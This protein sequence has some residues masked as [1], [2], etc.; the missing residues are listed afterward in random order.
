MTTFAYPSLLEFITSPYNNI[1]WFLIPFLIGYC[2]TTAVPFS[3]ASQFQCTIWYNLIGSCICSVHHWLCTGDIAIAI[4]VHRLICV[5]HVTLFR[6]FRL[7]FAGVHMYNCFEVLAAHNMLKSDD[8]MPNYHLLKH[9]GK[10]VERQDLTNLFQSFSVVFTTFQMNKQYGKGRFFVCY[11]SFKI[12]NP[13][14]KIYT[15]LLQRSSS[16]II[17]LERA[18]PQLWNTASVKVL[19]FRRVPSQEDTLPICNLH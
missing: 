12:Y 9:P 10:S 16:T 19:C 13:R 17:I 7:K 8:R 1:T 14:T 2:Q 5:L 18:R 11:L 3:L 4:F 6:S 15:N